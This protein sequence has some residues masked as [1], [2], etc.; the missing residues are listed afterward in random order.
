LDTTDHDSF[1]GKGNCESAVKEAKLIRPDTDAEDKQL[2]KERWVQFSQEYNC[3]MLL[4][5]DILKEN[6]GGLDLLRAAAR[7]SSEDLKWSIR[8]NDEMSLAFASDLKT[9]GITVPPIA[10]SLK[11]IVEQE[12]LRK[13]QGANGP[14]PI[15]SRPQYSNKYSSQTSESTD[16]PK[17]VQ[18]A[19]ATER[20]ETAVLSRT[21]KRSDT[22]E[23][24]KT[25]EGSTT[26]TSKGWVRRKGKRKC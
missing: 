13:I 6:E 1:N 9:E 21:T 25:W 7:I 19:K 22:Q 24:S 10:P 20:P 16:R 23:R 2:A 11:Q 5:A 18:R 17:I 12:L 4:I 26:I 3:V 8:M 15:G 14:L